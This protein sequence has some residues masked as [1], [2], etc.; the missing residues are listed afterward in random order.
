MQKEIYFFDN[1]PTLETEENKPARLVGYAIKYDVLSQDLGGFRTVFRKGAFG[2]LGDSPLGDL[3]AYYDHNYENGYLGRTSNGTFKIEDDGIGLKYS[4]ELPDTTLGRDVRT[5]AARGDIIGASVGIIKDKVAWKKETNGL[6]IRQHLS[7]TLFEVSV[8]HDPAFPST[9]AKL[10][11]SSLDI[12]KSL[13]EFLK[14][15]AR[16]QN[17]DWARRILILNS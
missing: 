8:V 6:P 17:L 14:Q 12:S 9:T 7:A 13:E 10:E 2:E 11:T 4:I 15:E 5:L 1:Q 16:T 3:K